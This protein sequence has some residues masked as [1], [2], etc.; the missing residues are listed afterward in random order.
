MPGTVSMVV[1][2]AHYCMLQ[3]NNDISQWPAPMIHFLVRI[4]CDWPTKTQLLDVL[5]EIAVHNL[6]ADLPVGTRPN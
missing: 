5:Y 1:F 6:E 3:T 4:M 2:A